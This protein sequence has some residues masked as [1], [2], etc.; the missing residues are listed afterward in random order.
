MEAKL[1]HEEDARVTE[2]MMVRREK[3]NSWWGE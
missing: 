1:G 3:G 2:D